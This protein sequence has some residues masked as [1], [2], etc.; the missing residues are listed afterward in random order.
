M[1][2][3]AMI[4]TAGGG[5]YQAPAGGCTCSRRGPRE[6]GTRPLHHWTWTHDTTAA[7][8]LHL[9]ANRLHSTSTPNGAAFATKTQA[10]PPANMSAPV[11]PG[12]APAGLLDKEIGLFRAGREVVAAEWACER[13]PEG[14][15]HAAPIA[16]LCKCTG[17]KAG[18]PPDTRHSHAPPSRWR[19]QRHS[20]GET[21]EWMGL[22]TALE[23]PS[24]PAA[25]T[26]SL[27][28]LLR[29]TA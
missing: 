13:C 3:K 1:E 14:M 11:P 20:F 4:T 23:H 22:G 8:A 5:R 7:S 27:A 9:I 28:V 12:L 6:H 19:A 25:A 21:D 17:T 15:H 26:G 18:G 10:P 2:E 29:D 16:A 24:P